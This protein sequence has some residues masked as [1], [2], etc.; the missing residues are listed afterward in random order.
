MCRHGRSETIFYQTMAV[1][2]SE[3]SPS[4]NI[5]VAGYDVH[6]AAHDRDVP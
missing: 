4:S 5:A 3:E 2:W 1:K 6:D